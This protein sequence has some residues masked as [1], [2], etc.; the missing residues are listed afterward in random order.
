MRLNLWQ[1]I[2]VA[3]LVV[4]VPYLIYKYSTQHTTDPAPQGQ[5]MQ[6]SGP[7]TLPGR[8]PGSGPG[9]SS[10]PTTAPAAAPATAPAR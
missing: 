8:S 2:A 5:G 3:V 4:T 1:W 9:P 10:G 7:A 6:M